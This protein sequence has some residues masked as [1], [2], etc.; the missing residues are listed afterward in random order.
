MKAPFAHSPARADLDPSPCRRSLA[1]RPHRGRPQVGHDQDQGLGGQH[2]INEDQ[3]SYTV[4]VH[5]MDKLLVGN[6]EL[7]PEE[8]APPQEWTT[9]YPVKVQ[10]QGDTM[11]VRSPMGTFGC[12]LSSARLLG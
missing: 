12:T 8:S 7:T 2:S 1:I 4:S 3:T 11:Y 9:N 6:Y 10:L 5:V